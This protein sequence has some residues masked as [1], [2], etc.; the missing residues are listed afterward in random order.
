MALMLTF[1]PAALSRPMEVF[2]RALMDLPLLAAFG[3]RAPPATVVSA[4][5]AGLRARARLEA[6]LPARSTPVHFRDS[7]RMRSYPDGYDVDALG[8]FP[9]GCPVPHAEAAG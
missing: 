3:Y 9:R 4:A 2:S 7:P 1:Y 6:L 5:R 8:T